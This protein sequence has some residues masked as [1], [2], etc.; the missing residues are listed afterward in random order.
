M[1]TPGTVLHK[2]YKVRMAL[3]EG[4]MG[5]VYWALDAESR[6]DCAIKENT[7]YAPSFQ[8]QFKREARIL[9]GLDHPHIPHVTDYFTEEGKQYLVM[10]FADGVDL[11]EKLRR[12]R[13]PF[14][15]KQVLGWTAQV[16]DALEYIHSRKP[17]IIHRDIKPANLKLTSEGKIMLVDFGIAK[18]YYPDQSTRSGAQGQTPHYAP[19]EQYQRNVRTDPRSDIYSLGATLYRLLT[20]ELPPS[21]PDRILAAVKLKPLRKLNSR[22][23]ARTEQ[24]I[25]RAMELHPGK[26]FPSV[27]AMRKA[28]FPEG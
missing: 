6:Q 7:G 13:R 8:R 22:I 9:A 5:A 23:S 20:Y 21:A 26:R 27:R 24:A 28:L 1:L 17:P 15:E 19:R 4:G 12:R 10:E 2:R 3:S 18:V 14:P 25:L 16:M 11:G